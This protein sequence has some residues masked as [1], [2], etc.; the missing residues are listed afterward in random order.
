MNEIFNYF[1][2]IKSHDYCNYKNTDLYLYEKQLLTTLAAP[3]FH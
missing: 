3:V 2:N 1:I